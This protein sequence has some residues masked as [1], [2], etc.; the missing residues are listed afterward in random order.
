M[1]LML[2]DTD[3]VQ[4]GARL[5]MGRGRHVLRGAAGFSCFDVGRGR[6]GDARIFCCKDWGA[7]SRETWLKIRE[8]LSCANR[9]ARRVKEK[10]SEA[11]RAGR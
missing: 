3:V 9:V 11:M 7:T 2:S 1:R 10:G 4:N 8:S 6:L 5:P